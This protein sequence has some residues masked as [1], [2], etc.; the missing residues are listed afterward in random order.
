[1][2]SPDG[3]DGGGR[4]GEVVEGSDWLLGEVAVEPG[5][6]A[7]EHKCRLPSGGGFGPGAIKNLKPFTGI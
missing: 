5:L 1:M 3:G 7:A 4:L 6:V 2:S